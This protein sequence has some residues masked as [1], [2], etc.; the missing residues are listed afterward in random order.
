MSLL[1]LDLATRAGWTLFT[2]DGTQDPPEIECGSWSFDGRDADEK[3]DKLSRHLTEFLRDCRRRGR[4]VKASAIERPMETV[5]TKTI[6]DKFG[7]KRSVLDGNPATL[8]MQNR[9]Y[10]AARAILLAFNAHPVS[11]ASATWRKTVLGVGRAP[12]GEDSR[13]FKREMQKRAASL[14]LRYGFDV[15]NHD[16]ADSLGVAIWLAAQTGRLPVGILTGRGPSL[17]SQAAAE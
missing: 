6:I 10:A 15:P 14:A 3:A 1:G 7:R 13:W 16:A 9:M 4:S 5:P 2:H 17:F 8:V 11:V 12:R